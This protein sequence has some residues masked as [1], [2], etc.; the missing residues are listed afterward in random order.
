MGALESGKEAL[1]SAL[2]LNPKIKYG[3]PYVYLIEYSLKIKEPREQIDAYMEKLFEYGNPRMYYELGV[4]FQKEGYTEE[5]REMFQKVQ[6]SFRS[7]PS[8]LRKQQRYYA[9]MAKIR[10]IWQ[11]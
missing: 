6:V 7:S 2:K 10:S 4:V 11:H 8:F 3:F 9:I 1:E 5:A